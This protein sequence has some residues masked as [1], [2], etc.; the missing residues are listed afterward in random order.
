MPSTP[1]QLTETPSPHAEFIAGLPTVELHVH[2]VGSASPRIVAELATRHPGRVP[3]DEAALAKYFTFRDFA[4]FIDLYLTVVD[5]IRTPD[6]VR[7]LTYEV[8]QQMAAQ[9][10][11]Y[12]EVTLTAYTSALR[13]VPIEAFVEAIEDARIAAQRELS[14]ALRWIFDIPGELGLAA[15]AETLGYALEHGP[16]SLVGFGLGGPEI[17]VPRPQ[18]APYFEQARAAGLHSIPHAGRRRARRPCGMHSSSS[19]PSASV[20]APRQRRTRP[21]LPTWPSATS[22]S[23]SV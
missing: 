16:S 5:L 20:T 11:R 8:A 14:I 15:G 12:A 2:H 13:G 7:L 9:N 18:F 19:A 6:D 10:V 3:A 17:G 4:H 22:R 1:R 23:R 21:S